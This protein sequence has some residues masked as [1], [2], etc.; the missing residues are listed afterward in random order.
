MQDNMDELTNDDF[1]VISFTENAAGVG[2]SEGKP[3]IKT[4]AKKGPT[5]SK[6]TVGKLKRENMLNEEEAM[7]AF[8]EQKLDDAKQTLAQAEQ[9]Q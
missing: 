7:A 9:D 6:A 4:Q 3:K 1:D 5:K 8:S 2:D